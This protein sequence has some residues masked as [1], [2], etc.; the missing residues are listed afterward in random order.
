MQSCYF[1]EFI[2]PPKEWHHLEAISLSNRIGFFF[3]PKIIRRIDYMYLQRG[4][5]IKVESN[6]IY[7]CFTDSSSTDAITIAIAEE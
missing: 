1:L 4:D 5:V 7:V 2:S 6:V 3:M